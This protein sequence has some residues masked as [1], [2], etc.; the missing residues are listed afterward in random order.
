MA[1]KV[2]GKIDRALV[3]VPQSF[4]RN[5]FCVDRVVA[6]KLDM[7]ELQLIVFA[8]SMKGNRRAIDQAACCHQDAVDEQGVLPRDIQICVRCISAKG[9]A[10]DPNGQYVLG[11]WL[12]LIT[13]FMWIVPD[14]LNSTCPP[15]NRRQQITQGQVFDLSVAVCGPDRRT[16]Q[17]AGVIIILAWALVWVLAWALVWV[18]VGLS[19]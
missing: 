13:S 10:S 11:P 9:R 8:C 19:G 7:E 3:E 1:T 16:L 4:A 6:P 15:E 5:S 14:P 2:F 12:S 18:G 17:K